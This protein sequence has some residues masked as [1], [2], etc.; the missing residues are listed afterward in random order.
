MSPAVV[1]GCGGWVGPSSLPAFSHTQL[2]SFREYYKVYPL[3]ILVYG[4]FSGGGKILMMAEVGKG[5][6]VGIM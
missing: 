3:Y 6:M 1:V 5:F 2:S 4:R